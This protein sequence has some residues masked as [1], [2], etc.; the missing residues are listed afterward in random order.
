MFPPAVR[1]E[2]GELFAKGP[3]VLPARTADGAFGRLT[4]AWGGQLLAAD[5]G[6]PSNS[7]LKAQA[8]TLKRVRHSVAVYGDGIL[9]I[10]GEDPESPDVDS[11]LPVALRRAFLSRIRRSYAACCARAAEISAMSSRGG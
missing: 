8:R 5:A 3:P 6:G 11:S 2:L 1:G 10:G 7:Q 9:N 4:T